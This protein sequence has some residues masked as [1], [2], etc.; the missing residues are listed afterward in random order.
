MNGFIVNGTLP[1][2]QPQG[3]HSLTDVVGR[4]LIQLSRSVLR[5]IACRVYMPVARA[6]T[7]SEASTIAPASSSAS[8]MC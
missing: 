5:R 1:V 7:A 6:L 3:V 4:A 2:N 8:P